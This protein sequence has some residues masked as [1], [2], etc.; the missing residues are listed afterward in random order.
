M[1]QPKQSHR[2]PIVRICGCC[3]TPIDVVSSDPI[4]AGVT[5]CLTDFSGL[6]AKCEEINKRRTRVESRERKKVD[7]WVVEIDPF[8]KESDVKRGFRSRVSVHSKREL[9]EKMPTDDSEWQRVWTRAEVNWAALGSVT[10]GEAE[11]F[12]EAI[13]I[14]A[15]CGAEMDRE[16]GIRVTHSDTPDVKTGTKKE[17]SP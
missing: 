11:A 4:A 7:V 14:A 15:Q 3:V 6:C 10:A 17:G 2:T 12:A 8:F 1:T 16:H 13:R 5:P 9:S